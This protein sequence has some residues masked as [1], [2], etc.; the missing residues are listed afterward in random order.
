M[1][2]E[3]RVRRRARRRV[4]WRPD[5]EKRDAFSV[6][7]ERGRVNVTVEF[8][9][10]MGRIAVEMR[11][12]EIGLLAGSVAIGKEGDRGGVGRPDEIGGVAGISWRGGGDG[13]ALGE[14]VDRGDANLAGFKPCDAFAIGRDGDLGDGPRLI[15]AGEDF[16]EF[17]R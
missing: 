6:G 11:E 13:L 17:G 8:S 15:F 10:A 2:P 9:E 16:V 5:I 7:R 14:I 1:T 12:I 4:A 3:G